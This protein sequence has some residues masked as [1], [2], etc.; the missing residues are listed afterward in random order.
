[1]RRIRSKWAFALV[2]LVLLG[3]FGVLAIARDRDGNDHGLRLQLAD[4]GF[5]DSQARDEPPNSLVRSETPDSSNA[6]VARLIIPAI[7]IDRPTVRGLLDTA[8]NEM[9][10]PDG[11]FDVAYYEYSA[12]PGHGNAVFSGHVDY[13][14][15]GPAV[16]WDLRKLKAGDVILVQ[17]ED[18]STLRYAV[19]FNR[20]YDAEHGPWGELFSRD[21]GQDVV[22]LYTCD[23]DFDRRSGNYDER[24]VVRAER[25]S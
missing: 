4:A 13:I 5:T 1:M 23:G 19:R 6:P 11:A 17:L 3:A 21:A 16:F 24:R 9:I 8:R 15:V 10:A 7:K 20:T 18:G 14:G 25:L 22:T 12:L 2:V